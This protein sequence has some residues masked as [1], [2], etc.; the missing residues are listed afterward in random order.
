MKI[1][2]LFILAIF[3]LMRWYA[4]AQDSVYTN[5]AST[6]YFFEEEFSYPAIADTTVLQVKRFDPLQVSTLKKSSDFQYHES[7]NLAQSLWNQLLEWLAYVLLSF[8]QGASAAHWDQV[9]IYVLALAGFMVILLIA[10]KVNVLKVFQSGTEWGLHPAATIH[11]NVHEMDFEELLRL[12]LEKENYRDGIRLLFLYALKILSENQLISW[13]AGKTNRDYVEELHAANLKVDFNLLSLYF[14][15]AWYGNF[16]IQKDTFLK[17]ED[18]F[19][20][21]K[22]KALTAG[23]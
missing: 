21:F 15:Y 10:L 9:L 11:E 14:D 1:K 12:A 19:Q 13:K 4:D 7:P 3:F 16:Q 8:F 20:V 6:D 23:R 5:S 18:T 2:A 22:Q 17:A